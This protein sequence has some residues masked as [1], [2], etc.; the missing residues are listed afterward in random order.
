VAGEA[1][2][3]WSY[4]H[5]DDEHDGARI[6]QLATDLRAEY[7]LVSGADLELFLDRDSIPWGEAWRDRI[8]Q[9]IA[10]TT[11]FIPIVTP[12]Y[13]QSQECRRELVNFISQ[14]R[15]SQLEQLLLPVYYVAVPELEHDPTDEAMA[16][17]AAR[18][19]E[20]L[21]D[22][23]L[24]DQSSAEYRRAVNRLA[25]R[26]A[27]IVDEVTKQ[28]TEVPPERTSES[29]SGPG[30]EDEGPGL[31]ERMVDAEEAVPRWAKTMEELTREIDELGKLADAAARE[32]NE[33]DTRGGGAAGRLAV[34][35]R[36]AKALDGPAGRIE[37]LGQSYAKDL[38]T[39][40]PV[41][42]TLLEQADADESAREEADE[43]L[44]GIHQLH[45]NSGPAIESLGGLAVQLGD[46]SKL[47]RSLRAP[48]R[49]VRHGLQGV[50]DGQ[51]VIEGWERR[52]TEL[53]KHEADNGDIHESSPRD[54]EAE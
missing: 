44:G 37:R 3:F 24:V 28:S 9:A 4:V 52:A 30:D 54:P 20:D 46:A 6:T 7:V 47:S 12:A 22:I 17:V 1:A 29:G 26:I 13:F 8:D 39:I 41:V 34:T 19:W 15:R 11:F 16:I 38:V 31:L 25:R 48:L 43:F 32:M 51:S 33:S 35:M 36:F 42:L 5:A 53:E 10:G 14:A 21:R 45:A 50:L 18:Q 49:R 27:E 2:G 23:R 40:D